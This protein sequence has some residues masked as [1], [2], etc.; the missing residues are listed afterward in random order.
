MLEDRLWQ[1]ASHRQKQGV[2]LWRCLDRLHNNSVRSDRYLIERM[3]VSP[4]ET[5]WGDVMIKC[6]HSGTIFVGIETWDTSQS[7]FIQTTVQPFVIVIFRMTAICH[8]AIWVPDSFSVLERCSAIHQVEYQ[9]IRDHSEEHWHSAGRFRNRQ[10]VLDQPTIRNVTERRSDGHEGMLFKP[11]RCCEV[12]SFAFDCLQ[13]K[14]TN[15]WTVSQA[16]PSFKPTPNQ[17]DGFAQ[18]GTRE[19]W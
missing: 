7:C 10:N 15:F 4:S 16:H 12:S 18:S 19:Y 9:A 13:N 1:L 6:C 17:G 5:A 8:S 14:D 3:R 11:V 2:I